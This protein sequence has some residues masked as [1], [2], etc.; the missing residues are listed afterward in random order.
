M[1]NRLMMATIVISILFINMVQAQDK[2][3]TTKSILVTD[4]KEPVLYSEAARTVR[5]ITREQI[6]ASS[7]S[8]ISDLL[9]FVSGVDVRQRGTSG[10]QADISVKGGS[11]EQ[12]LIL[13]NGIPVNDPQTGH[14][15]MNIPIDF[16]DIERIEV[17]A[18]P[19][20]R[21][22]GPNAFTGAVNIITGSQNGKGVRASLEGGEYAYYKAYGSFY[23]NSENFK[24][25]ISI[26]KQKTDGFIDN[27]DLDNTSI[28][29]QGSL[30]SN[31]GDITL[32]G[33]YG[34]KAFGGNSFY[35]SA[36]PN[37]FEEVKTTFAALIFSSGKETGIDLQTYWRR[38]Q[39]RFELYRN[40][41][42]SWYI[43]HNYHLSDV[44]GAEAKAHYTSAIGRS[45]IGIEYRNESIKSNV[46]GKLM[47]KPEDVPGESGAIF[48]KKDARD[49]INIFI[50]HTIPYNDFLV[51]AGALANWNSKF[52]IHYY[53]GLDLSW[54]ADE[55]MTLSASVNQS[56]RFPTFTDLYYKDP[57]SLGN[58][59]LKPEEAFTAEIGAKYIDE[60]FRADAQIFHRRA[61][62][63]IDFVKTEDEKIWK[64]E[65]ITELNT[66]GFELS[67]I[68]LPKRIISSN[69]IINSISVSYSYIGSEKEKSELM[70]RYALDYLKHKLTVG[71]NHDIYA[72][73]SAD[74]KFTLQERNGKYIDFKTQENTEYKT[75]I[76]INARINYKVSLYTLYAEGSN[77]LN[78]DYYDIGNVRTPG[79]W[80][81]CG[82][83]IDW[84]FSN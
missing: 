79:R 31:I 37:Q 54:K 11:F 30:L 75:M 47:D 76:L 28:F 14:H 68:L 59:N 62:N 83:D 64:A 43:G 82:I 4:V 16:R 25:L 65:N 2:V 13:L 1:F 32:M 56:A 55:N 23:Y 53:G 52:D 22:M 70:S 84:N 18:G 24:N 63:L 51:S 61:K 26:T 34:D 6:E 73:L 50:D 81:R 72:G 8:S 12:T 46:L 77:L 60:S 58:P 3:I 9:K 44:L 71:I 21:V 49:N 69:C 40:N 42:A 27:T 38:N 78:E 29:Y 33:G 5:V 41:P 48:T 15:N 67:A 39:D 17:L 10:A 20:S 35:S 74:W 19:G 45:S 36:Y 57:V 80:M 66:T 7:V